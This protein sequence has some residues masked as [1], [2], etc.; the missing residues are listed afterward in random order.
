A[1]VM[2]FPTHRPTPRASGAHVIVLGNEKGGSG[3]ST[4]AMHLVIGLLLEQRR[5]GCLDL[6]L[7]QATLSRYLANRAEF[8]KRGGVRLPM[9]D[10]IAIAPGEDEKF[11]GA[12]AE[13]AAR[14][15]V[16]VIDC[17]GSDTP[18]SRA[19]HARADT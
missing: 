2:T 18:L 12:L 13:L 11:E 1:G 8:C 4:T 17:P 3:K 19:A 10:Q 16:I 5:V 7:R 14:N 6:D 15:D 9:P